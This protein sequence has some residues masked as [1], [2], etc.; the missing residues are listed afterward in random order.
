MV[1][2]KCSKTES[3]LQKYAQTCGRVWYSF[4]PFLALLL[5]AP[6]EGKNVIASLV[7]FL[8]FTVFFAILQFCRKD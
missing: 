8:T 1:D 5:S 7:R 2:L 4:Q 6:S 3:T